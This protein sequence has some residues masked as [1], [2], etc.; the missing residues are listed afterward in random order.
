VPAAQQPLHTTMEQALQHCTA[1]R[2][3]LLPVGPWGLQD[4]QEGSGVVGSCRLPGKMN[5]KQS[6]WLYVDHV[7]E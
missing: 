7:V 6:S 3:A 5:P 1:V 4:C 2:G